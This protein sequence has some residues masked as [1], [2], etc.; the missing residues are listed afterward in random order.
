MPPCTSRRWVRAAAT[1]PPTACSAQAIDASY[2]EDLIDILV[3]RRL[4]SDSTRQCG[5]VFNLLGALSE[6]GELDVV[7]IAE[8]VPQAR[9]FAALQ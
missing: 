9:C 2:P 8:S 4:H 5:V 1:T 3:S 7:C 6:F